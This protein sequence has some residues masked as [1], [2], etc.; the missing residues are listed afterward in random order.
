[1]S[2][3][4]AEKR[5]IHDMFDN[6]GDPGDRKVTPANQLKKII[7]KKI[8]DFDSKDGKSDRDAGDAGDDKEPGDLFKVLSKAFEDVFGDVCAQVSPT[9]I[10]GFGEEEKDD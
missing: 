7:W 10:S 4:K 9:Y 3:T 8:F 2:K 1:M 6:A 5:S